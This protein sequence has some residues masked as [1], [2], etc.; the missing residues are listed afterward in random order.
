MILILSTSSP[1]ASAAFFDAD[2]RELASASMEAN[3]QASAAILKM[4]QDL[5]QSHGLL[6]KDAEG[7]VADVGPGSFTG[8]KVGV[9]MA[10]TFGYAFGRKAAGISSFDLISPDRTVVVPNVA[11]RFFV[12]R[13]GEDGRLEQRLPDGEVIGYG[14]SVE[15]ALYPSAS[16]AGPLISG[17][18]WLAP[19]ALVPLYIAEPNISIPKR[20]YGSLVGE[21]KAGGQG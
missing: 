12:R 15:P 13:P 8:V 18:E 17:L 9:T 5:E 6:A 11:G 16:N 1:V 3:R 10:K 21:A 4:L 19:E 7:F 2:G 20:A 14:P